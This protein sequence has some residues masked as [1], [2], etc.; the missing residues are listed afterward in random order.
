[1]GVQEFKNKSSSDKIV[2]CKVYPKQKI[3]YWDLHAGSVYKKVCP[4]FVFDLYENGGETTQVGSIGAVDA[5]KKWFFDSSNFTL[6]YHAT[7]GGDPGE[8]FIT[9]VYELYLASK[10]FTLPRNITSGTETPWEGLISRV[11]PIKQQLDN[12]QRGITIESSGT[13]TLVND[14]SFWG[15]IFGKYIWEDAQ[16]KIFLYSNVLGP[17]NTINLF[18]GTISAKTWGQTELSFSYKDFNYTLRDRVSL[19]LFEQGEPVAGFGAPPANLTKDQLLKPKRRVYGR[20]DGLRLECVD[21]QVNGIELFPDF[22]GTLDE[23]IITSF[24]PLNEF[25]AAGDEFYISGD[26]NLSVTVATM[27]KRDFGF[28]GGTVN[29]TS[30]SPLI[31]DFG[32]SANYSEVSLSDRLV[33]AAETIP[34]SSRGVYQITAISGTTLTI[35]R[36]AGFTTG[37]VAGNSFEMTS[38]NTFIVILGDTNSFKTTD[39]IPQTFS[40]TFNNKLIS[41]RNGVG[42]NRE[43]LVAHHECQDKLYNIIGTDASTRFLELD[44][45]NGLFP[46][47]VVTI[48]SL[49]YTVTEILADGITIAQDITGV[50]P[51]AEF[52]RPAIQKLRTKNSIFTINDDFII[53]QSLGDCRVIFNFNAEVLASKRKNKGSREIQQIVQLEAN[54]NILYSS[55]G[56]FKKLRNKDWISIGGTGQLLQIMEVVSENLALT[57]FPFFSPTYSSQFYTNITTYPVEYLL[58]DSILVADVYGK[59]KDGTQFGDLIQTAADVVADIL[60]E[61]GIEKDLPSFVEANQ[62]NDLLVSMAIPFQFRT[63][64]RATRRS[65]IEAMNA[66]VLGSLTNTRDFKA[67]YHVFS[68]ERTNYTHISQADIENYRVIIDSKYQLSE[69]KWEYR[70]Q[71]L[72][73]ISE[74]GAVS[75]IIITENS[76]FSNYKRIKNSE[77]FTIYLYN[78]N[79]AEGIVRR[80]LIMRSLARQAAILTA[81]TFLID[82]KLNDIIEFD[83]DNVYERFGSTPTTKMIGIVSEIEQ[84]DTKT[85]VVI[86][87]LGNIFARTGVIAE[88]SSLEYTSAP[89]NELVLNMYITDNYGGQNNNQDTYGSNLIQ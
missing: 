24:L 45:I 74:E 4:Q 69:I 19:P 85:T 42:A 52:K 62:S 36:P 68:T 55:T 66:S 80:M 9:A 8:L 22:S 27:C 33:L 18:R 75:E 73:V 29:I 7:G 1:M 65:I 77:N 61:A 60:D 47:D 53:N 46:G 28:T 3:L 86:E 34:L 6:Y 87:D 21:N 58:D 54:S 79:E 17:E 15:P 71:D 57:T 81:P 83:L 84:S 89:D 70:P 39:N 38:D 10:P 14:L 50:V 32:V 40:G 63:D 64:S 31:I 76:D 49:P 35:A 48:A 13:I 37:L 51:G 26:P 12:Q 44:S 72:D 78:E 56:L 82:V 59:T 23:R 43:W 30:T 41:L 25:I 88:N 11:S 67:S 20:V 5:S 2:L 16:I